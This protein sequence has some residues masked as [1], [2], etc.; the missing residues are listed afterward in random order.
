[1]DQKNALI[2][3]SL[4][5]AETEQKYTDF[6]DY[7]VELLNRKVPAEIVTRLKELWEKTKIV[8]GEVVKIGKIIAMKIL[9]FIKENP[10][11]FIGAALGAIVGSFISLIPFIGP[12]LAPL[13]ALV[14]SIYGFLIGNNIDDDKEGRSLPE[15]ALS[16]ANNFLKLFSEILVSIKNEWVVESA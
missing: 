13:A 4:L 8:A 16:A 11:M 6:T 14:G 12:L 1:M 15:S 7:S 2:E 10:V 3:L 5:N 9:E